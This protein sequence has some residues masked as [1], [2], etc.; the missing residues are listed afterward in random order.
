[1]RRRTPSIQ[2]GEV[3]LT[4]PYPTIRFWRRLRIRSAGLRD[5]IRRIQAD[6]DR[7][8]AYSRWLLHESLL[9]DA[10]AR[11]WARDR[12]RPLAAQ[13]AVLEGRTRE[14]PS[15]P[16]TAV[17]VRPDRAA[18][19]QQG[20]VWAQDV[21]EVMACRAEHARAKA[22]YAEDRDRL[23]QL[24]SEIAAIEM[25][26]DEVRRE[27]AERFRQE[28]SLYEHGR[29]RRAAL[30]ASPLPPYPGLPADIDDAARRLLS[31]LERALVSPSNDTP[32]TAA[33]PTRQL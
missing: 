8:T 13:V 24:R 17:P 7:H 32:V 15:A 19:P 26:A 10:Q 25:H 31:A 12:A 18:G 3:D 22:A 9:G 23:A 30:Q 21:R 11:L 4:G 6:Q 27:W 28:A 5:R 33:E 1:M 29:S 2:P 20:A 16:G 14:A